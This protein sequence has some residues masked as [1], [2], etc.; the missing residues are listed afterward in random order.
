[1]C[2]TRM[3]KHRSSR[4]CPERLGHPLCLNTSLAPMSMSAGA[5][6]ATAALGNTW[7]HSVNTRL[8]L[9]YTPHSGRLLRVAKSPVAPFCSVCPL[10]AAL[11]PFVRF[12]LVHFVSSEQAGLVC[13]STPVGASCVPW[14]ASSRA[15]LLRMSL[16]A[17]WLPLI[18]FFLVHSISRVLF[19]QS[20]RD[21][22]LPAPVVASSVLWGA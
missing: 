16:S 22:C 19:L 5:G 3:S 20:R 7:S 10:S 14:G 18:G 2:Q 8:V 9:E 12:L 15:L 17:A 21:F 13:Q 6:T 11:L 1:M 4:P